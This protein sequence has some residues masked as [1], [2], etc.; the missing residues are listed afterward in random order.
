MMLF[1]LPHDDVSPSFIKRHVDAAPRRDR[2]RILLLFPAHEPLVTK[3]LSLPH[4]PRS[5]SPPLPINSN[6]P[7]QIFLVPPII[8]PYAFVFLES[9]LAGRE[10]GPWTHSGGFQLDTKRKES[11]RI[12]HIGTKEPNQPILKLLG[13]GAMRKWRQLMEPMALLFEDRQR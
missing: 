6:Q 11:R 4:R 7:T 10:L 1:L 9:V 3:W 5:L 13:D 12:K 2:R 8:S